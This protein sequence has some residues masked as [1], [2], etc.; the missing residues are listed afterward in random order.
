[1]NTLSFPNIIEKVVYLLKKLF[2]SAIGSPTMLFEFICFVL[3]HYVFY[4]YYI[5]HYGTTLS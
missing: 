2:L 3:A 1:M 5:D 4:H